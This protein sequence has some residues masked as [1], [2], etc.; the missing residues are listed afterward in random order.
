[1]K[2]LR[3]L[4]VGLALA[5]AATA[6]TLYKNVQ[7]TTDGTNGLT[8]DLTLPAARTLTLSGTVAGTPAGGTLSLA[9]LTLTLP[10]TVSGGTGSFQP[11]DSD[12]TSWAAITRASGFDT[13][14]ATPSSANLRSLLTDESGTGVAYFQGGDLGTPSA[15]VLTN[16]T[17][18]PIVAGTTGTLSA[19]RGGTGLTALSANIVSLLGAADYAAMRT[20]LSLVPG[21]D[22]QAY[23]AAL[24]ALAA[25]SDFV[26]FTGPTT[27]TK[28]FTLP[29]ASSTLLY[30]GGPLGTPSSGTLTNA[31]GLPTAGL[32]DDAVTFAKM[33][34]IATDRLLGRDTAL[35]GDPEEI[36]VGGGLEFTGT[37][38]IQRSALTG[39]A[40]ASAGSNALTLAT[41]NSNVGTFGSATQASVVTV[42]GKGLVTAASNATVTP[43]VGSIT[44]LGTGVAT[45]LAANANATGG[46]LTHGGTTGVHTFAN[47]GLKAYDTNAS[48]ALNLKWNSDDTADR[49]LNLVLT[50]D[51]TLTINGNPT[52]NDWF[53]QSVKSGATPT[54]T[55][56]NFTGASGITGT[57]ALNSG[58]ITSGFGSIDIGTDTLAA[59]NTTITGS[60]SF[61]NG[62][63]IT[64][65][66][67]G[68]DM[69]TLVQS[70]SN[71][72]GLRLQNSFAGSNNWNISSS[73][74]GPSANGDFVVY[75]DTGGAV[76]MVITKTNRY[77]RA[78]GVYNQTTA[79]A[80]NVFVDS[81]GN[82]MRSTSSLRYKR[83]VRDYQ[84]GL[85]DV[86]KLRPVLYK[87]LAKGDGETDFA[88]LIAEE[89]HEAGLTEFVVY[90]DVLHPTETEE[91]QVDEV[92][93]GEIVGTKTV[94]RPKVVQA[95]A[96]D[97]LAYAN[98]VTLAFKAIQ[99][100]K[101]ENDAL[102][103]RIEALEA[104]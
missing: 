72:V 20:Q 4:L 75:D 99:E 84:R 104:K 9:N 52:L 100:L 14:V 64:G 63:S 57:G 45:A 68:F 78:L 103:A 25:G 76:A 92:V 85:A 28:V 93:D 81:S 51:R 94:T 27:S 96:P 53:D 5:S 26:Q 10:T 37:G 2:L 77:L 15:G 7:K 29:D 12:L 40:T 56:T 67:N 6:Q 87:G 90:N 21:T 19:A 73:G 42:N 18:L 69:L 61:S 60:G 59:G 13:F 86:M 58:S 62:V 43:A 49:T 1:M 32:V 24:A 8:E 3:L 35:T 95:K 55:A 39:D 36:T 101:A 31:T 16:A 83:D 70:S 88:G 65:S 41:V 46:V 74:G 22:V 79:S 30:S 54:F 34:N 23:D 82:I 44:G 80:A 50:A 66:L 47:I 17:G 97:A 89:V 11:V 48:H 38:G 98:M 102:R 71:S 91:V 33:Q